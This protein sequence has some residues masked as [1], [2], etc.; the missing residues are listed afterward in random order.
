MASSE[1]STTNN[2]VF[3]NIRTDS[4]VSDEL[5]LFHNIGPIV[6]L[7]NNQNPDLEA[8][9]F[10]IHEDFLEEAYLDFYAEN[11]IFNQL[12][13][14]SIAVLSNVDPP[15]DASYSTSF[16]ELILNTV[17]SVNEA[18]L[19]ET[20]LNFDDKQP[21]FDSIIDYNDCA[22]D[23]SRNEGQTVEHS[24]RDHQNQFNNEIPLQLSQK[25]DYSGHVN[26]NQ[27]SSESFTQSSNLFHLGGL[28]TYFDYKQD[29]EKQGIGVSHNECPE[30]VTQNMLLN[31]RHHNLLDNQQLHMF[32][33]DRS[34]DF[35][36]WFCF[37]SDDEN[38]ITFFKASTHTH[39]YIY[40][41]IMLLIK[42]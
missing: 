13:E 6:H 15:S 19:T 31:D 32:E 14:H 24:R 29:T 23:L 38:E 7:N 3:K 34:K 35:S 22:S 39:I 26:L 12:S 17:K 18:A 41:Y 9:E 33:D 21:S 37:D 1:K 40:I 42:C 30:N 25:E 27:P 2:S 5:D 11:S 16:I 4:N 10:S 28:Q 8:E 20:A 36:S